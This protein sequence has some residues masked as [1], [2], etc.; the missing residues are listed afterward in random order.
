MGGAVRHEMAKGEGLGHQRALAALG[1]LW[2]G[3][4]R[5]AQHAPLRAG[6]RCV[7]VCKYHRW[8]DSM[9]TLGSPAG[10]L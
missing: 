10:S 7:D 2:T 6:N 3:E 1:A 5:V 8:A 9:R 4:R